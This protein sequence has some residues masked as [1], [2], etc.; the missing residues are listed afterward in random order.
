MPAERI[1]C[2]DGLRAIAVTIVLVAHFG[3]FRV[4]PGG[5]GVT[6]FFFI[7]G[8]LITQLL[9][10]ELRREG[11][12]DLKNFYIRRALRLMPALVLS[13]VV[14]GLV[15]W[16]AGGRVTSEEVLASLFYVANYFQIYVR[17]GSAGD[18]GTAMHPFGLYW[19]LAVEEQYYLFFPIV[20]ALIGRWRRAAF[21]A[22]VCITLVAV[23]LWRIVLQLNGAPEVRIYAGTDTRLDSILYGALAA[24]IL[25]SR[26]RQRFIELCATWPVLLASAIALVACFLVRDEFF[27]QTFRYS[28]QGIALAPIFV[29]LCY[30]RRVGALQH[31]LES[32]PFRLMGLWSYSLYLFHATAIVVAEHVTGIDYTAGPGALTFAWYAIALSLTAVFSLGSYYGVEKPFMGMR[33]RFGSS[34]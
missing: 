3:F 4:V 20:V 26:W 32:R 8:F 5:F 2:L 16:W 17:F 14:G 27:R 34:V 15:Y 25:Q 24:V 21:P 22:A 18:S 10:T 28:I 11:R 30:P 12:I 23:L 29:A 19:S 7:S 1:L 33:R 31:L 9:T 13:I 6:L